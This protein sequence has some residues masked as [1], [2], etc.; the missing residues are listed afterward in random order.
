MLIL[1]LVHN[2]FACTSKPETSAF[3]FNIPREIYGLDP[4]LVSGSLG[5]FILFNLH[6]GLYYFNGQNELTPWGARSCKWISKL[7]FQCELKDRSWNTGEPIEAL[8]YVYSFR[9]LF[10]IAHRSTEHFKDLKGALRAFKEPS[11]LGVEALS[12]KILKFSFSEFD[13]L[14]YEKLSLS[15]ISPRLHEK[16]YVTTSGQ[17]FSGPFQPLKISTQEIE[18]INNPNFD[19]FLRPDVK[20]FFIDDAQAAYHLYTSKK[21]DFLRHLS[22]EKIQSYRKNPLFI[23]APLARLDGIIFSK[24]HFKDVHLRRA[25]FHSLDFKKLA[26]I[27]NADSMPGCIPM[28]ESLFKNS[29]RPCYEFDLKTAK[30]FLKLSSVSKDFKISLFIPKFSYQDHSIFSQWA[31]QEW[32][33]NLGLKVEIKP[34]EARALYSMAKKDLIP[35]YRRGFGLDLLSCQNALLKFAS[36]S[37]YNHFKLSSESLDNLLLEHKETFSEEECSKGFELVLKEYLWLPLGELYFS[38]LGSRSFSGYSI[39]RL[40]QFDLTYL[41]KVK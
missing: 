22:V 17:R 25:L 11:Q 10:R 13:P 19:S 5:N 41:K 26:K 20:A 30:K 15:S 18:L 40:D 16:S 12:P 21:L 9:N 39:N 14:F 35:L 7:E 36:H 34:F 37:P 6:R 4:Q 33:K 2:L 28:S 27:F 23:K 3:K 24:K 31:E 29:H 38:H 32:S 1:F 8:H